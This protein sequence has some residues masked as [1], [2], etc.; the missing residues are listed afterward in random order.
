MFLIH[1]NSDTMRQWL[2]YDVLKNTL[3]FNSSF[4]LIHAIVSICGIYVVCTIIDQVRIYI[5]EK[6]FLEMLDKYQQ[7]RQIVN[8]HR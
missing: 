4:L 8:N 3:F 2:W 7:K 6:P 1:T 5:V